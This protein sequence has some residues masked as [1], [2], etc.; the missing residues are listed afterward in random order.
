MLGRVL[1][2]FGYKKKSKYRGRQ[3]GAMDVNGYPRLILSELAVTSLTLRSLRLQ[4]AKRR[5]G[6]RMD[7]YKSA[8]NKMVQGGFVRIDTRAHITEKGK[9]RLGGTK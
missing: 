7:S 8:F 1:E 4:V 5:D 3:W 2:Y 6:F 9:K